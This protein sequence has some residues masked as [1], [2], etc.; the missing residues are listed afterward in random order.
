MTWWRE[1]YAE[2]A[3]LAW[4]ILWPIAY[5]W[6]TITCSTRRAI[7]DARIAWL[8]IRIPDDAPFTVNEEAAEW[9]KRT[10]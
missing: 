5:L 7:Y 9:L 3:S 4:S 6:E 2:G 1:P 8:A 10:R